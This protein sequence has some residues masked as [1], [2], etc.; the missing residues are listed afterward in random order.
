MKLLPPFDPDGSSHGSGFWFC[1][2]AVSLPRA[3]LL[4]L[5]L[6]A[7]AV[8]G[9]DDE[10]R[11]WEEAN[12]RIHVARI[13]LL[14][15]WYRGD[16]DLRQRLAYEQAAVRVSRQA[17]AIG[18]PPPVQPGRRLEAYLCVNDD[19]VQP[20][21]RI[22]PANYLPTNPAPLLVFLHGY[23]P[24]SDFITD[25]YIP[26][27]IARLAEDAGACVVA[28]FGRCNSDYQGIGEQDVI[29]VIDE[30]Q[31]RYHTDPRRVVLCG[32][33][34]GGLGGWCIASR[35]PERF[36]GLLV[37]SG[38]GD[39]YVWHRIAPDNV[40]PWQRRLVDTQF[41]TAWLPNITNLA[42]LAAHGARD[43]LVSLTQGRFVV[44]RLRAH[45]PHVTFLIAPNEGHFVFESGLLHPVSSAWLRDVLSHVKPKDRPTGLRVGETGSRLQNAFLRPFIFVGGDATNREQSADTLAARAA[46]WRRFTRCDPRRMLESGINTNL[47]AACH[48]FLFGE[49][50]ESPLVRRVLQDAG[51]EVTS[52]AFRI[53]GRTLPRAGHGLWF[54][55]RNPFNPQRLGIVQCG[56]PWGEHLSD[57]HRYDR[58]PDV[59][60]YEPQSDRWGCNLATAAGYLDDTDRVQWFDPPVTSA[61]LPPPLPVEAAVTNALSLLP[62]RTA[63]P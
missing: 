10:W 7:G 41:A 11:Q 27:L 45:N 59:I 55:G 47:A 16:P 30:M 54:T 49:P 6:A 23:N 62:I 40:P 13:A 48:L 1:R 61:I 56:I 46:E 25:P 39:Y 28:P 42:V 24:S 34:M 31:T 38:R 3:L 63:A 43:D 2:S 5:L 18:R 37:L 17:L 4:T 12:A 22:L 35:H 19:S 44:E 50:E 36:N 52:N 15:Q 14:E 20:F 51:V 21:L 33:S 29:R 26:D 32:L 60:V 58:I 53:A 9:A 8:R 57:N